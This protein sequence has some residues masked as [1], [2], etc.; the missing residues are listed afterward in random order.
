METTPTSTCGSHKCTKKLEPQIEISS[1][2]SLLLLY[3]YRDVWTAIV[4]DELRKAMIMAA[5]P[6]TVAMEGGLISLTV[7]FRNQEPNEFYQ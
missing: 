7:T 2:W 5:N 1:W 6:V 3:V 4:N